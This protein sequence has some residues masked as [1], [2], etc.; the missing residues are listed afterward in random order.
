MLQSEGGRKCQ[1]LT[2][3]TFNDSDDDDPLTERSEYVTDTIIQ[4]NILNIWEYY[5]NTVPNLTQ[6]R[7]GISVNL[8]AA[9][10]GGAECMRL[11]FF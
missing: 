4:H 5:L 2:D 10:G 7:N 1:V 9:G 6:F 8:S 3:G 11:D